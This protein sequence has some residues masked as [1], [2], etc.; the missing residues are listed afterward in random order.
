MKK[1]TWKIEHFTKMYKEFLSMNTD[2]HCGLFHSGGKAMQIQQMSRDHAIESI[3]WTYLHPYTFYNTPDDAFDEALCEIMENK[4]MD[5]YSVLDETGRLFGLF[6]YSFDGGVMEIGLGICPAQCGKGNGKAFV[7]RCIAFGRET[8]AYAGKIR[9]MVSDF[10][11]RAIH[12]YRSLG[13][14]ETDRLESMSFGTPGTFIVME[15]E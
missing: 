12:L 15:M 11:A 14:V 9:L 10:N 1:V 4:G 6:E 2:V 13:F 8:Y 3:H 7:L 5:Y